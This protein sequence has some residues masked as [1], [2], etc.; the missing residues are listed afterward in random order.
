MRQAWGGDLGD[1]FRKNFETH[2]PTVITQ[3]DYDVSTPM[4]NSLELAPFF[5]KGRLIIVHGGSH[6]ALDDAMDASATFK[7]A[8]LSF[9]RAGETSGLPNEIQLP[10]IQWVVPKIK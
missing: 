6:P 4:E 8:I 10:P 1:E 9:A 7:E 5:K 2:I 3:G